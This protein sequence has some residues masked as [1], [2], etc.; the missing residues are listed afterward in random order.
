MLILYL[1]HLKNEEASFSMTP[2]IAYKRQELQGYIIEHFL[3][4][5]E[6]VIF[7]AF[8]QFC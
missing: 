5:D 8:W 6:K 7:F 4:E 2:N 3:S 1:E